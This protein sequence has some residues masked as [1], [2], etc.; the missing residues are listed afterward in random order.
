MCHAVPVAALLALVLSACASTPP[1][2]EG[3]G[4]GLIAFDAAVPASSQ[5]W[6][7]PEWRVGDTFSLRR[8]GKTRIDFRVA[9]VDDQGYL[10]VDGKGNRLR[11]GLD[12]SNVGEWAP[13][14]D[15]P[16]HVLSPPDVRFHWPLWLGKK[17]RC[18]YAD[19]T[20]GGA[21]LPIETA[22]E[23]ED[24]DTVTTPAGTF[25]A[26]RILRTSRL[27]IDDQSFL[28]RVMVVW[29][30]PDIGLEV[31]QILGDTSVELVEWA[32]APREGQ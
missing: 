6:Q 17:W 21:A 14:G 18:R 26:L 12:L 3:T 19:R 1:M 27:L 30:A 16:L 10:L 23:V 22:Y 20:A 13:E 25:S 29:Y 2:P 15:D 24:L 5:L 11:R 7:Q 9:A 32:R 28:E 8:G 31:R 4:P